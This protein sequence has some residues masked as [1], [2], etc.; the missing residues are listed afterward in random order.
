MPSD[1]VDVKIYNAPYKTC[2]LGTLRQAA[3]AMDGLDLCGAR[4][5]GTIRPAFS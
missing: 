5:F 3:Q 1:L 2:C 4:I